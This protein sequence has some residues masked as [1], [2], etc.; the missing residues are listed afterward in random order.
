MAT[1]LANE[2]LYFIGVR[3]AFKPVPPRDE[4]ERFLPWF[5]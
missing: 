5:S 4:K 1:S 3:G 2:E